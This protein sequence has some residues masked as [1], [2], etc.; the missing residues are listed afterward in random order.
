MTFS[1]NY[2][3]SIAEILDEAMKFR[4]ATLEA[5]LRFKETYPWRGSVEER[6]QKFLWL[7][8]Q[9]CGIYGKETTLQFKDLDGG[10]SGNS[11]YCRETDSITIRGRLSVV[12]YLHEFAHSLGRDEHG[13]CR[14]SV[15]LFRKC[16]PRQFAKCSQDGHMLLSRQ[17]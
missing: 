4:P 2:P 15:N 3:Q 1:L 11:T 16:F 10:S 9:L 14:W 5:V 6:K 13:A 12:T 7:H 8:E 17:A